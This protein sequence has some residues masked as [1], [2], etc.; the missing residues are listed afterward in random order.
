MNIALDFLFSQYALESLFSVTNKLQIQ[1]DKYLQDLTIRQM[2]VIPAI[3]HAPDG[4]ATIN[5]I[6]RTLGTTKQNVKQIINIM[7]KKKYISTAPSTQDKRALNIT[8]TP[9]GK[10]AFKTCSERVDIFLADI[11]SDFTT[12]DLEKFCRLLEKLHRLPDSLNEH[13]DNHKGDDDILQYHQNYVKRRANNHE[14][15]NNI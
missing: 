11:F 3:I 8:V 6:A 4:K 5:H 14:N 2:L 1:G 10:Q 15:K 9:E 12:K 13:I 7:E